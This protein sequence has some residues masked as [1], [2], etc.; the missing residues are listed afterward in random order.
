M[1]ITIEIPDNFTAEMVCKAL[2]NE[3]YNFEMRREHFA[4]E[5]E[6]VKNSQLISEKRKTWYMDY[7]AR[8][9]AEQRIMSETLWNIA[10]SIQEQVADCNI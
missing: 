9:G 5:F 2:H 10:E 3:A 4:E 7:N 8:R 1:K 6:K